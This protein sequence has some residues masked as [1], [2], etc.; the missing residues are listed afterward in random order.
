MLNIGIIGLGKMGKIRAEAVQTDGRGQVVGIFDA[1]RDSLSSSYSFVETVE[2]WRQKLIESV[3]EYDDHLLEKYF[4][5]PESITEDEMIAAIREAV[6][7]MSFSPVLC[8]SAFKNK[9]VQALLDAQTITDAEI[10]ALIDA[11]IDAL[12]EDE[13]GATTNTAIIAAVVAGVI[14]LGGSVILLKF[15]PFI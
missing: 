2:E 6:I 7:D 10:Q 15:N 9:G 12:P 3:A 8:G 5:D 4:E 11:A 14:A 1:D 13:V